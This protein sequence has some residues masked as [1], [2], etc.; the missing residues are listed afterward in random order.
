MSALSKLHGVLHAPGDLGFNMCIQLKRIA[1][2]PP[3]SC[4]H[5]PLAVLCPVAPSIPAILPLPCSLVT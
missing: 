2:D 4:P 1:V 3:L 5:L